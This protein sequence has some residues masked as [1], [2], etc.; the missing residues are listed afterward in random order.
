MILSDSVAL[1]QISGGGVQRQC[2]ALTVPGDEVTCSWLR[3]ADHVI[4]GSELHTFVAPEAHLPSRVRANKISLYDV[5]IRPAAKTPD[6]ACPIAGDYV[7]RAGHR[8]ADQIVRGTFNRDAAAVIRY[9]NCAA[10][11]GANIVPLYDVAAG[12]GVVNH[13]PTGSEISGDHV[14]RGGCRAADHIVRPV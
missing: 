13:N 1:Y 14:A 11:I 10:H 2:D 6:C 5:A 4:V 7:T 12:C 8:P 9:G 3:P